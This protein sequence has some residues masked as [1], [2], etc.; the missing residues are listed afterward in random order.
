[1]MLYKGY[2]GKVEYDDEANILHGEVVGV[3]DVI[4]FAADSASEIPRA[5]HDSVDDYLD[6]CKSRGEKPEK[7][8]SGR[9]VVRIEPELHRRLTLLAANENR[10]LNALVEDLLN[11]QADRPRP[12]S[13]A[14]KAKS[15]RSAGGHHTGRPNTGRPNT[16]RPNTG[17]PKL[18][19]SR[20]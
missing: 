11:S 14:G 19:A 8:V 4:T 17:R 15:R 2:L 6:F 5:F 7:P 10:S 20:P 12:T 9:F 13:G 18:V 3:R 1:M 16:V